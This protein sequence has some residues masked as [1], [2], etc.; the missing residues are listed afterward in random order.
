M[1]W[2]YRILAFTQPN[3]SV[4][5]EVRCVYYNEDGVTCGYNIESPVLIENTKKG[6]RL[7]LTAIK[8]AVE[9]PV[10]WGDEGKFFKVYKKLKKKI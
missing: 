2:N 1:N 3:E 4:H 8:K 7:K 9:K 10:L 6:M 5:F